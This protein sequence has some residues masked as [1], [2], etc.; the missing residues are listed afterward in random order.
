MTILWIVYRHVDG[1]LLYLLH[2]QLV[3]E[4]HSYFLN[5]VYRNDLGIAGPLS[6]GVYSSVD[7]SS[8]LCIPDN[9]HFKVANQFKS[10]IIESIENCVCQLHILEDC[11][12]DFC[13]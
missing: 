8:N 6:K 11:V 13:M 9:L 4:D 10:R 1:L 5:L 3:I 7:S 2:L 12:V